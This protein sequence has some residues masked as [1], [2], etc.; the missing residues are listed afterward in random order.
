MRVSQ[1]AMYWREG[2][3]EQ[4][5]RH[6]GHE[7]P[8]APQAQAAR[9]RMRASIRRKRKQALHGRPQAQASFVLEDRECQ[10]RER[11]MEDRERRFAE[12]IKLKNK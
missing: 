5:K 3:R 11:C 9:E 6:Y 2:R 10:R 8:W 12:S 7:R 1:Q 4:K